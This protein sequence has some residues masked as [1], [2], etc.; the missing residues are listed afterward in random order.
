[1]GGFLANAGRH[2]KSLFLKLL[3]FREIECLEALIPH[4]DNSEIISIAELMAARGWKGDL[5][6]YVTDSDN[7]I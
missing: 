4:G 2:R 6:L 7:E 1:M 5:V 3:P